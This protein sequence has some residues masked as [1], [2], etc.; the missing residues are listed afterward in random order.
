[1]TIIER[2][3]SLVG[4]SGDRAAPPPRYA[5]LADGL[6][7]TDDSC[8]AWYQV[9]TTNSDLMAEEEQDADTDRAAA[10]LVST[11]A[12]ADVHLRVLWSPMVAQ[13]Y[14]AEAHDLYCVGAW[15][16]WTA[17]RVERL[18]QIA[19][20]VRHVLMGVRLGRRSTATSQRAA[21]L[22][23][24]AS[25][26]VGARELADWHA[27][28]RR[29]GRRL[30]ASPWRCRT[31]PVD[32]LAWMIAREQHRAALP[33]TSSRNVITGAS[34]AALTRGRALPYPD[35]L[36]LVGTDGTTA[37]W[38][39][40]LT[41]TDYPERMRVPGPGEWLRA[42]SEIV[43]ARDDGAVEDPAQLLAPV[44][45]EASVR[46]RV[47]P[48][49]EAKDQA[50]AVRRRA[51]EQ[52]RSASEG[53]S[54]EDPGLAVEETE[55][56]MENL[57]RD[58]ERDES[59]LVE[60][61]A[62]IVVTS[63]E[64]LEDLRARTDAVI[65][66]YGAVGLDLRVAD[67]E[68]RELWL[69]TWAGD[70]LRVPDLG[71]KR[72]TVAMAGTWWWGGAAVGDDMGPVIG[73]LTGSTPGLVRHSLIAGA[74]R[75]DA[76][77]TAYLG[78]SGRG[79]TTAMMGGL[80][81]ATLSGAWALALDFKG[82]LG[83]LV[84]ASARYGVPAR[85]LETDRAMP[86]AVDLMQLLAASGRDEARS[87]VPA[88]LSIIMPPHLRQEGAETC[89]Q[90]AV[91]AVMDAGDLG[92]WHVID[93]LR[94]S[95]DSLARRTGEALYELAQTPLGAPVMGRP[96]SEGE[97]LP[98]SA[99]PGQWVVQMPGL[100]LPSPDDD[101]SGWTSSQ[102]LSVGLMHSM[103]A[104]GVITT[105]RR[106]LRGMPKVVGIPE[107]HVLT[108]TPEGRHFLQ[109]IAR[110]GRALGT[111]L[112]LDS[113]DAETL[114]AMPG[115]VEQLSTVFGFQL[116]SAP[117]ANAL[118]ELLG[119]PPGQRSRDLIRSLSVEPD[120]GIRRGYCI[121][122]DWRSRAATMQWDLPTMEVL[123]LLDTSPKAAAK[124]Y[125]QA[126]ATVPEGAR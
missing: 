19:L 55:T 106:D 41:V 47:L 119:L 38:V 85:L 105:G 111:H 118:A 82:D 84:A 49:R 7:L 94:K 50:D 2:L 109:W 40:V 101:R 86:G 59:S 52:R 93:W 125:A 69:E 20:P 76:T 6:V 13:D 122:R 29:L 45:P 4:V 100:S 121:M 15:Q 8:W 26:G 17:H 14:E 10:A 35:H 43:Y 73:Y 32:L 58:L 30:E 74:D 91:N 110:V 56:T 114:A 12:G 71:H 92:T 102:R 27:Q 108:S 107:V 120:G 57:V 31:A 99:A 21:E 44:S 66:Y 124:L 61:Y 24:V 1:M 103:L 46:L 3:A 79:K 116:T 68:Q 63:T 95:T 36:R 90:Q 48:R 18:D 34:L 23:G 89:V 98:L 42:L 37:A 5:G 104:Y 22:A 9:Q 64:G 113:Q 25:G 112:A 16:E 87:E 39:S 80:L 33:P 11:L 88:Q 60:E 123:E 62:R 75:G 70:R 28:A 97:T 53:G 51:K 81:D 117:Q 54:A 115:V 77:T 96:P 67:E 126:A 78:R 72:D 65:T 83:G